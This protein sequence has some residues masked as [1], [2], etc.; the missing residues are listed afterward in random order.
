ES[1]QPFAFRGRALERPRQLRERPPPCPA[2]D[3]LARE[4]RGDLVPERARLARAPV[5]AGGLAHEVDAAG[6]ARAGG[7]EEVAAARNLVRT[8]QPRARTLVEVAPRIVGE[9]R[10]LV[11]PPRQASFFQA[12]QEDD[13]EA[14]RA[15]AQ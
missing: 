9:E 5:V 2:Q 10:R 6:R 13:F 11:S 1:A 3:V 12:E 7:V 14:A 4:E 8:R 15:R